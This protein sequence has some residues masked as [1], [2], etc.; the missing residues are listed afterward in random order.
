MKILQ[1]SARRVYDSVLLTNSPC[2]EKLQ[3]EVTWQNKEN[4][5]IARGSEIK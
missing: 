2:E 5:P 4:W 3:L 1:T